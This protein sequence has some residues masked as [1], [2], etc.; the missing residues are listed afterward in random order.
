MTRNVG[1]KEIRRFLLGGLDEEARQGVERR[2]LTEEDFFEELLFVE[3]E[4]TD[5]YLNGGLS[6]D[7]RR[8]FEAH[9]LSTP[10]RL[11]KLSFAKALGRY[12][13]ENSEAES[14]GAA[15]SRPRVAAS[16]VAAAD[17]AAATWAGRVR[18]FW[19]ARSRP[20]RAAAA[21]A[22]ALLMVGAAWLLL[23]APSPRTFATLSLS[24]TAVTRGEAARPEAVRL[25]PDADALK[26][27]LTLPG[28][29]SEAS[30][31]GVEL[32]GEDGPAGRL[33]AGRQD[34]RTI[35]VVIPASRLA[36]GRYSLKVFETGADS[37]ERRVPGNYF[38]NVE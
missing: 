8:A 37:A 14:A 6:E 22:A 2:L 21:F 25:P 18:A 10:E 20:L 23:R 1:D 12:V 9:F 28:G 35:S 38:F 3:E 29:A 33:E 5:E 32:E 30:R 24:P 19:G 36:R 4:L 11:R 34:A 26:V 15:E 31:F 13:S 7:E 17:D 27:T 16:S